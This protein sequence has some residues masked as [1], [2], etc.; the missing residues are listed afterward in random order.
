MILV[1]VVKSVAEFDDQFDDP[2]LG[3]KSVAEFISTLKGVSSVLQRVT[4]ERVRVGDL[5]R[6]IGQRTD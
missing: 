4:K 2:G 6:S 5:V 1:L 3:V